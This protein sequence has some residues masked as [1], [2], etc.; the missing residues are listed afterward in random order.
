M[1]SNSHLDDYNLS[2]RVALVTGGAQGMGAAICDI[3]A[4]AGSAVVVADVKAEKAERVAETLRGKGQ[5]AISVE[6]D[7]ASET[8]IYDLMNRIETEFGKLDILVNN[9]GIQDRN[10][11]EDTTSEYWDQLMAINLR[12]PALLTR[13]TVRIMRKCKVDGRIVNIASNSAFHASAPSLYAYSTSKAGLAGLTR[14]T[15][16]EVTKDGIRAN[17]IC[18]G[19]TTTEGQMSASGPDFTPEQ[20]EKFMPPIGRTGTPRDIANAVLFLVSDASSFIT[21]QT[22]V[23]DGGMLSC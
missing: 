9:A 13:E 12:G 1:A 20:I 17:A 7:V 14:A 8:S 16:I 22:L 15:A 11:L 2:D 19:N 3:L 23:V 18:P 21:G 5:Q 6:T 10:F 4:A